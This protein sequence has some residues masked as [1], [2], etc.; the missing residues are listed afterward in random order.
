MR[1]P[2]RLQ[3]QTEEE[4]TRQPT[5]AAQTAETAADAGGVVHREHDGCIVLEFQLPRGQE[6]AGIAEALRR[7]LGP[8]H[9][10]AVLTCTTAAG[11]RYVFR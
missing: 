1:S 2:Q 3:L 11:Q 7:A 5:C 10:S 6:P 4:T 9:K 8:K